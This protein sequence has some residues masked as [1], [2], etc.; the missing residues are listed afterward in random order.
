VVVEPM[1]KTVEGFLLYPTGKR[2]FGTVWLN[3]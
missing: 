2:Y 3:Q 1:K